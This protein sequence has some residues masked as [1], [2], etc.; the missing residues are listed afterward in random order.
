M[1]NTDII[2]TV[3]PKQEEPGPSLLSVGRVE[4]VP[5]NP[6]PTLLAPSPPIDITSTSLKSPAVQ[7]LT[8]VVGTSKGMPTEGAD[9]AAGMDA[10]YASDKADRDAT[11]N[12]LVSD[13]LTSPVLAP[14][15]RITEARRIDGEPTSRTYGTIYADQS[16]LKEKSLEVL[17]VLRDDLDVDVK[18]KENKQVMLNILEVPAQD[19]VHDSW[20]SL[21]NTPLNNTIPIPGS[22][23]WDENVVKMSR[24]L[25]DFLVRTSDMAKEAWSAAEVKSREDF[26]DRWARFD[27]NG[28]LDTTTLK[29]L[30][31][32]VELIPTDSSQDVDAARIVLELIDEQELS[33]ASVAELEQ[34]YGKDWEPRFYAYMTKEIGVDLGALLLANRI[35]GLKD[36]LFAEKGAAFSS[37]VAA[38][39]HRAAVISVGGTS[40]EA[41]A[42][43]Y[44]DQPMTDEEVASELAVR[45]IGSVVG[46]G[47]IRSVVTALRTGVKAGKG[48]VNIVVD[49]AAG[50]ADRMGL[51]LFEAPTMA[52][53]RAGAVEVSPTLS[54]VV[55]ASINTQASEDAKVMAS[56]VSKEVAAGNAAASRDLVNGNPEL[57]PLQATGVVKTTVREQPTRDAVAAQI[58]IEKL[59]AKIKKTKSAKLKE[60]MEQKV[61]ELLPVAA[62][63]EIT[64]GARL[65]D[66]VLMGDAVGFRIMGEVGSK[67][68]AV[69]D[70]FITHIY[71]D[72][73]AHR[74]LAEVPK[75]QNAIVKFMRGARIAEGS[76]HLPHSEVFKDQFDVYNLNARMNKNLQKMLMAPFKGLNKKSTNKVTSVLEDGHTKE[77]LFTRDQLGFKGLNEA[78]K[79]T[80]YASRKAMDMTWLVHD[81]ALVDQLNAQGARSYKGVPV[82]ITK[83]AGPN[84]KVSIKEIDTGAGETLFTRSD[85]S[86]SE[87]TEITS[88]LQYHK[89][90]IPIIYKHR[91]FHVTRMDMDT[92]EV[93][94]THTMARQSQAIHMAKRKQAEEA[95]NVVWTASAWDANTATGN[96]RI[97]QK[98]M[99]IIDMTPEGKVNDVKAAIDNLRDVT[100][101]KFKDEQLL[102]V[103][104]NLD[105]STLKV[106]HA[107]GR[108]VRLKGPTDKPAKQVE[109]LEAMANYMSEV[110]YQKNI[111]DWRIYA[112][113]VFSDEYASVL[114]STKHWL[115]KSAVVRDGSPLSRDAIHMQDKMRVFLTAKSTTEKFIDNK[116]QEIITHTHNKHP[117]VADVF[118]LIPSFATFNRAARGSVA[119]TKL[120]FFSTSQL[121]VQGQQATFAMVAR[122]LHAPGGLTDFF[123]VLGAITAKRVP[124]GKGSAESVRVLEALERSGYAADLSTTD[125]V[126]SLM[127]YHN[128]VTNGFT[129]TLGKAARSPFTAGE[130]I[131]RILSFTTARREA[132]SEIEKGVLKGVDGKTFK[133][134]IDGPEFLR[135]VTNKAKATALDMTRAGQLPLLSGFGASTLQFKQV[136]PKMLNMFLTPTL[137]RG[138]KFSIAATMFG[139]YGYQGIPLLAD[140]ISWVDDAV[141]LAS[142][143]PSKTDNFSRRIRAIGEESVEI[144][145]HYPNEDISAM[146]YD[147]EQVLKI[148]DKGIVNAT[149]PEIDL[150]SRISMGLFIH[151]AAKSMS[152]AD[153]VPFFDL[154]RDVVDATDRLG[155]RNTLMGF[156]EVTHKMTSRGMSLDDALKDTYADKQGL[157]PEALGGNRSGESLV[158]ET[159][160]QVGQVFST[161]GHFATVMENMRE[162]SNIPLPNLRDSSPIETDRDLYIV[163]SDKRVLSDAV[164]TN[165]SLVLQVLGITPASITQFHRENT[166]RIEITQRYT[167]WYA[168]QKEAYLTAGS[169]SHKK[170]IQSETIAMTQDVATFIHGE[171]LPDG[172]IPTNA[173]LSIPAA[174]MA[175]EVKQNEIQ[176]NRKH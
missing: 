50:V 33:A 5:F 112:R 78:E 131:N 128:L 146:G 14:S 154:V 37:R 36:K 42:R 113:K 142:D 80:Y 35:P 158:L 148:V 130:A 157:I 92:G 95:G 118:S 137:N 143:D 65:A 9:A 51:P 31:S 11:K 119:F 73:F 174:F 162:D 23:E 83:P 16:F 2:N 163:G 39:L 57:L 67:E 170:R 19:N 99:S 81:S 44:V 172:I 102:M 77:T 150:V 53:V 115:D 71:G 38:V 121:L 64:T 160:K 147:V 111:G 69:E 105:M 84:G 135:I 76:D 45:A 86:L 152:P 12:Q 40:V 79:E 46:E 168:K 94:R 134:A 126:E 74:T 63:R 100:G 90:Y 68:S 138:Q 149:Y 30:V 8:S 136:L 58:H 129:R 104:N 61:T 66:N 25:N 93:G 173:T 175:A 87:L 6:N 165:S 7:A 122:P 34:R 13:A 171:E 140:A 96:V 107:A 55:R 151:D 75:E 27:A 144:I 139:L 10:V 28:E 167:D 153:V 124:G 49:R 59:Q 62:A 22:P 91:K 29:D 161:V 56:K 20:S 15:E 26:P 159:T 103:L 141:N 82:N 70:M 54:T 164:I 89:G 3:L 18:D 21:M 114:D 72:T 43:D 17:D 48:L 169:I 125:V 97:P 24:P 110:S 116:V 120:G 166:L 88:V 47:L 52:K 108:K 132:L 32:W 145:K 101:G 4:E 156:M 1:P 106:N 133:G 127:G 109:S 41:L 85:V 155:V 98:G 176:R 117:Y 60:S 123:K